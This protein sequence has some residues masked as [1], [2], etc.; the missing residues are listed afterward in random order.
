MKNFIC[1]VLILLSTQ[2]FSQI[3]DPVKWKT[4]VNKISLSEYELVATA[5]I[6][7][8]WHMYS[9]SV[10]KGGPNPTSFIFKGSSDYLKRGNTTE[11]SGYEV[12]DKTYNMRI[13]SFVKTADFKQR[14]K[15]KNKIP[16]KVNAV[17]EFMVCND[18][19]CL[20]SKEVDLVF[21]VK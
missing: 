9:Q 10:P 14:I 4:S 20:P 18:M 11:G 17:V 8:N 6:Q 13:K 1:L 21:D 15:V 7:G 16:F 5:S 12:D 19:Q 2:A 3:Y